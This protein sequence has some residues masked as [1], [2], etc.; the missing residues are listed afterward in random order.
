MK[1][2][3]LKKNNLKKILKICE[4]C[5]YRYQFTFLNLGQ[6]PLCDDLI[7]IGSKISNKKYRIK[8]I[9]CPKCYT[10]HHFYKVEIQKLF[11][12]NYHYRSR[13]TQ[14]VILGMKDLFFKSLPYLNSTKKI[15]DIGCNDGSLL[16]FYKKKNFIT[17]G[18]EPTNAAKEAKLKKHNIYNHY[19]NKKIA[20]KVKRDYGDISLI[21]FTN[22]FAHINDLNSL[23]DN[24]K[25]LFTYNTTLIIENHYLGSVINNVQFD[26][27]Y[28]EHPRTYSLTS[29]KYIAEKLGAHIFKVEFT[30]R[31]FGNIRV[32]ISKNQKP[33]R[34]LNYIISK[35]NEKYFLSKLIKFESALNRWKIFKIKELKHLKNK[36]GVL[37]AKAF[38]GRASVIINF[39]GLNLKFIS[40]AFEKP[41][42]K[43]IG[44]YI[45]GTK[46]PILSDNKI[47]NLKDKSVFINLAWHITKE[48][49]NYMKNY[50]KNFKIFDILKKN[51]IIKY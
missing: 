18:V 44:F 48:I 41:N 47:S 36:Y 51:E 5:D 42:S 20:L 37:Y 19:F 34:K 2:Q 32:Y 40:A 13:F 12:K 27:F 26:T 24:L 39:L 4:V 3:L 10:V 33:L 7:K 28:H 25:I 16:D 17:I 8:L 29:F 23:I 21:T 11:P 38:P 43:K 15:L 31:Y 35:K 22:V 6:Q 50:N 1:K 30:K 46:I 49:K 9:F 14:D 45:P